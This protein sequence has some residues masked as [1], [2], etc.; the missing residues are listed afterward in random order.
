MQKH[1]IPKYRTHQLE[2]RSIRKPTLKL[3]KFNGPHS[4]PIPEH[5]LTL[6]TKQNRQEQKRS[7]I[8]AQTPLVSAVIHKWY[9]V[10][11]NIGKNPDPHEPADAKLN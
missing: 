4:L 2:G 1:D 10:I 8:L 11:I 7:A 5:N 3:S 9:S 6:K